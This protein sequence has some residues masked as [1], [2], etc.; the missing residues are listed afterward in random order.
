MHHVLLGQDSSTSR[1][2]SSIVI[3]ALGSKDQVVLGMD[4]HV[5]KDAGTQAETIKKILDDLKALA[6]KLPETRAFVS[7][8]ELSNFAGT[9]SDYT[10]VNK[11]ICDKLAKTGNT[12]LR[13]IKCSPHKSALVEDS[14]ISAFKKTSQAIS[15]ED[16]TRGTKGMKAPKQEREISSSLSVLYTLTNSLLPTGLAK[17]GFAELFEAAATLEEKSI[18]I[19]PIDG[20]RF[21]IYSQNS[22]S[23]TNIYLG[24]KG[25]SITTFERR[26]GHTNSSRKVWPMKTVLLKSDVWLCF[27]FHLGLQYKRPFVGLSDFCRES[28]PLQKKC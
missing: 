4:E 9:M 27:P 7:S 21:H 5:R 13:D 20:S 23:L 12:Y 10:A 26:P 19:M 25:S 22:L 18:K 15:P 28:G 17:Y 24:C 2:R 1:G 6:A 14:F 8:L 11:V 3:T 16:K